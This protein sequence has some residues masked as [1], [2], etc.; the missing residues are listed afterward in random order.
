M[1][2][3]VAVVVARIPFRF[4]SHVWLKR[5]LVFF[6]LICPFLGGHIYEMQL[7]QLFWPQ[8][9]DALLGQRPA[10]DDVAIVVVFLIV[11]RASINFRCG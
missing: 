5:S 7:G 3:L 8:L 2:P 11:T 1:S 9:G 4:F 6:G 10:R